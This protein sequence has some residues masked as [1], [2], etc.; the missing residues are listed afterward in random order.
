[1]RS[2]PL[3]GRVFHD[4]LSDEFVA[5]YETDHIKFVR[6]P[7]G[8]Y[9]ALD[10][11]WQVYSRWIQDHKP[12]WSLFTDCQ[13]VVI[14][15]NP[16]EFIN[17]PEKLYIG[18][19]DGYGFASNRVEDNGWM[20]TLYDRE[21]RMLL[22][23]YESLKAEDVLNCGMVGGHFNQIS[24]FLY[25]MESLIEAADPTDAYFSSIS[26]R[27]KTIDMAVANVI[28]RQKYFKGRIVNGHPLHNRYK[29]KD[30][31]TDVYVRHK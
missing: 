30:L 28:C 16:F 22:R 1:M 25:L 11:R 18:R 4:G 19:E 3:N 15:N 9:C 8:P 7:A 17:D 23:A 29:R 26:A 31:S 14:V 13:D 5:R 24:R 21:A 10:Y 6:T 20:K 12:E 27:I 2:L